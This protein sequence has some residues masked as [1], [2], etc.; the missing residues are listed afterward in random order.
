MQTANIAHIST[1][2]PTYWP[3]DRRKVPDLIDF[4]VVK[5]ISAH[6]L[7]AESSFDLSSDHS[8]VLI[9]LHSRPVPKFVAPTLSKKRTN[10]ATFL[11]PIHE[12]LT[13]KLPLKT[14]QDI[15]DYVRHLVQTIQQAAWNST[16]SPLS[17]THTNTCALPI[18]QIIMKKRKLH[19]RWQSTRS[20]QD[21]AALNKA[22]KE[23]KQLL[24]DEKQQAIQAYL[25]SL[26]AT[27]ATDYSLWKATKRLKQPQTPTPPE[28]R[29]RRMGEK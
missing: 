21:K 11:N 7:R 24:H 29:R 10:W 22:V 25:A 23:L 20:P 9:T 2:Q 26:S 12:T 28:D 5:R 1:G 3:T 8:P 16:P 4:A 13:L 17:P 18:K 6:S 15:E 27:E 14:A 19:K